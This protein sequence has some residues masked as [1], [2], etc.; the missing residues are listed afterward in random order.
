M[1]SNTNISDK[2]S[3]SNATFF[4]FFP[5]IIASLSGVAYQQAQVKNT[6][7]S[8]S[9]VRFH[10]AAASCQMQV[11]YILLPNSTVSNP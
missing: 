5:L 2:G 3:F 1:T 11:G 6:S 10:P 4:V 8:C 7:V 9:S